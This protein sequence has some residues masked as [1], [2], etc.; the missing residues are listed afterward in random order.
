MFEL[1]RTFCQRCSS[2]GL[3]Q[4]YFNAREGIYGPYDTKKRA[5]D[6]L[7]I[8]IERR[9][10]AEDNGGRG[11]TKNKLSIMPPELALEPLIDHVKRKNGMGD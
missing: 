10:L 8:F 5:T 1:D 9:K 6:E 11:I 4:W 7:N 2:T 3:M